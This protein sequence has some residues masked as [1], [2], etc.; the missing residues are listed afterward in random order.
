[1]KQG[2]LSPL[3]GSLKHALRDLQ[4]KWEDTKES[5][6]D[7]VAQRF[8]EQHVAPLEIPVTNALKAV[9]RLGQAMVRAYEACSPERSGL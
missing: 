9:D 1:M 8:E 5:W 4:A 3:V 6:T 2:D 7:V